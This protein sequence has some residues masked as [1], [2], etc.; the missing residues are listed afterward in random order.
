MSE[1]TAELR[2]KLAALQAKVQEHDDVLALIRLQ[3]AYGYY[4]DK[5]QYD[6]AADLFANDA[7]L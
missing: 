5:T 6:Q 1:E 2:A 7:T 3:S 4:V